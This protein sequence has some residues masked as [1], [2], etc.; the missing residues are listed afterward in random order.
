M[1]SDS[2]WRF[3]RKEKF[4]NGSERL[5]AVFFHTKRIRERTFESLRLRK[6]LFELL[7]K[8]MGMEIQI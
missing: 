3:D 1:Y 2:K 7:K 4:L 5:G 8:K 6:T